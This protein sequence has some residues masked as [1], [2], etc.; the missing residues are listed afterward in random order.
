MC[1]VLCTHIIAHTPQNPQ[2]LF[3]IF[4]KK[5]FLSIVLLNYSWVFK[6][7]LP[8]YIHLFLLRILH[9]SFHL[10]DINSILHLDIFMEKRDKKMRWGGEVIGE[11]KRLGVR[12]D[13]TVAFCLNYSGKSVNIPPM[14]MQY[15]QRQKD[16]IDLSI[17]L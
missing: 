5:Y 15:Y 11:E 1:S 2:Y 9:Y 14:G 3:S 12:R 13:D 8:L 7:L 10:F 6:G 17:G 4:L 16:K